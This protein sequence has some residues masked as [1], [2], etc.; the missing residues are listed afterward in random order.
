M[1]NLTEESGP[2]HDIRTGRGLVWT[3]VGLITV[4]CLKGPKKLEL[5]DN[6][7]ASWDFLGVTNG[8]TDDDDDDDDDDDEEER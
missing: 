8:E 5:Y 1:I 7:L 6:V 3:F 4:I 2:S